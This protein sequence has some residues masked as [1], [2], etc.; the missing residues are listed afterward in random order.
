MK[1]IKQHLFK[2]CPGTGKIRGLNKDFI[3][4]KLLFPV[5]GLVS[6]IWVLIRVLP[7]PSRA[8]YP[9]QSVAIPA[10]S[11]FISYMAAIF[12]SVTTFKGAQHFVRNRRFVISSVV[13]VF[14]V[15]ISLLFYI[16]SG[17][18]SLA[19]D[20]GTFTPS[21]AVNTPMGTARGIEPGRVAWAYDLTACNWDGTS[22]YWWSAQFNDQP[23]ITSLLDKVV[24]SVA[25]KSTVKA[26]WNALFKNHNGGAGY[27]PGE[28]IMIKL[29]LNNG[30][31][32]KAIDASPQSV[33]ALL[34]QLVNGL[35][36][37]QSDILV[38]DPAREGKGSAVKNYCN[39][40]FPDVIYNTNLG[41]W[42]TMSAAE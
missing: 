42:T 6:L 38:C 15:V 4:Y 37:N 16:K 17:E 21:D 11:A 14:G 36:V 10:A 7:K 12:L 9:C 3:L 18:N 20:T 8:T 30:G 39:T 24:C 34:E 5:F 32:G 29:N 19:V 13:I 41:G 33:F 26:S 40:A 2:I 25:N 1:K 23:K 35:G 31:A 28:K 22:D 27:K